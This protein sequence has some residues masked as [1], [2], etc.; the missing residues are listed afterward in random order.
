MP[1]AFIV[2]VTDSAGRF[3]TDLEIPSTLVFS[4]FKSKLLEILRMMD[5]GV[6]G[7]LRDYSLLYNNHALLANDSLASIGAFDG[8]RLVVVNNQR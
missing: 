7:G 8:S 3:E 6:F 1:E 5:G 2:T 4:S